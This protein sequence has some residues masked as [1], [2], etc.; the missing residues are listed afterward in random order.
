MTVECP[1]FVDL[2]AN[3]FA[4]V[5]FNASDLSADDVHRALGA[6]RATGVT[7]VLPTLVTGPIEQFAHCARVLAAIRDPAVAG[8]HMEG[9]YI[10][11]L[12]GARGAHPAAYTR[13]ASRDDF[14]RRQE[15]A[16]GRI[17][18]V[19]LAPEVPG[20]LDLV[21][22]LAAAGVRIAIGH[23]DA[24]P[25]TIR[26]AIAAGATLST[27]LGNGCAA[28]L[29][30]HPNVIWEQLA[31][32]ELW[33]SVIVDGHHLPGSTVKSLVRAKG[34]ERTILISD[35]TAAAGSGPGRYRLGHVDVEVTP[36]GRSSLRGTP[37]LAG[38]ALTIPEAIAK[39]IEYT[40]LPL[41]HVLAMAS[42]QP[43]AYLGIETAGTVSAVF[44]PTR[45]RL[46]VATVTVAA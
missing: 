27:H 2:Q 22:Y 10:S 35:A 33:M 41:S 24:P 18:L 15:S 16:G 19:T 9:P 17:V 37:Y 46:E 8:I 23:T 21:E 39:T 30:R 31:A 29:P 38:S 34:R 36:D 13:P 44:D 43:A 40:G 3:G 1:G 25:A 6:L 26:D 11:P 45:R 28:S 7:R 42:T 4:G 12:D 20:A 5:D 14:A 32:D